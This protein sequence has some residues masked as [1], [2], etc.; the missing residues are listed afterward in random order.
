MQIES[1]SELWVAGTGLIGNKVTELARSKDISVSV[2]AKSEIEDPSGTAEILD[3]TDFEGVKKYF[4]NHN[5][6]KVIVAAG[7]ALP[8]AAKKNPE[9]AFLVN[10]EGPKNI[11][12][13][14]LTLPEGRRPSVV[15][16][17]SALQYDVQHEGSVKEDTPFVKEGDP[18]V[19]SKVKMVEFIKELVAK[20]LD[21][22]IAMIFNS[23]GPEQSTDYFLP[24]M[25]DQVAKIKLGLKE[26]KIIESRYVGHDRDFSHVDD[27]A[28]GI[29]LALNGRSGDLINIASGYG[30][31]LQDFIYTLMDLSGVRGISHQV[32]PNFSTPPKIHASWGDNS[33]LKALGF[34]QKKDM[35]DICRD[36]FEARLKANRG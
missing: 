20:G 19:M 24:S 17:G 27:T 23:T 33:R 31:R 15:F 32:D 3:I 22:K 1:E 9:L 36:L 34:V 30:V 16:M 2:T 25:A 28:Q 12:K 26:P 7:I 35:V 10:A 14:I 8:A 4:W 18:Y 11:G 5:F 13:A 6:K 21:A 29:M